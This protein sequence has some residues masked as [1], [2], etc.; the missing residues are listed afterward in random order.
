VAKLVAQIKDIHDQELLARIEE[1]TNDGRVRLAAVENI[2][3]QNRL[4]SIIH[5]T[6]NP[7]IRRTAV[8]HITDQGILKQLAN[9]KDDTVRIA[10]ARK[11]NDQKILEQMALKDSNEYVGST[12][13]A[14]ITDEKVLQQIIQNELDIAMRKEKSSVQSE[15][16]YN[17]I[18]PASLKDTITKSTVK[19][20]SVDKQHYLDIDVDNKHVYYGSKI[21]GNYNT[22]SDGRVM[23]KTA[24]TEII[25]S[26]SDFVQFIN[27]S[28]VCSQNHEPTMRIGSLLGPTVEVNDS[29]IATLDDVVLA[30]HDGK[31][32][33][34]LAAF[35][36]SH[37][38]F[39]T[40]IYHD[41]FTV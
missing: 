18:S 39:F 3:D 16:K 24:N 17:N 10:V 7:N 5:D 21:I 23:V 13:R 28:Q 1:E 34:A 38:N 11:I 35:V 25:A 37:A 29:Y 36:C 22:D 33:R 14:R 9:N 2:T 15:E 32:E 30:V 20:Y 40:G 27:R 26:C 31:K 12:A 4:F 41:F 19:C 6:Q 8:E